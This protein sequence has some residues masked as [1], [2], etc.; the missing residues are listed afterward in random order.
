MSNFTNAWNAI[1]EMVK[2]AGTAV[3]AAGQVLPGGSLRLAAASSRSVSLDETFDP[4]VILGYLG[5]DC[6]IND[7][8]RLGPPIPTHANLDKAYAVRQFNEFRERFD[9]GTDY[10]NTIETNYNAGSSARKE[11]VRQKA[12]ELGLIS[13]A[14]PDEKFINKLRQA[15]DANDAEVT[16]K[17]K[18]LAEFSSR[19][20]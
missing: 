11:S 9:E 14:V 5:F 19:A 8:G 17:F 20:P 13:G 1:S 7:G 18:T 12:L 15:F 6:V 10:F 4:P 2:A 16:G 3:N